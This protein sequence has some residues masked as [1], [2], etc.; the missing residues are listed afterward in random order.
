MQIEPVYAETII[1]GLLYKNQFRWY[2]TDKEVWFLDYR[3]LANAYGNIEIANEEDERIG[4]NIVDETTIDVFLAR[5]ETYIVATEMLHKLL[6]EAKRENQL[7]YSPA[8]FIDV[9]DRT[10]YSMF[11]EPASY[12][13]YVPN[14]WSGKYD[15]FTNLVPSVERY[16]IDKNGNC[17]FP[18]GE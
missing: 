4:I 3:K 8:L 6:A 9:D 1:V 2:V 7:D 11:P 13:E 5:I 15:D 18:K 14:G 10:L 12:E 16:W 17:L